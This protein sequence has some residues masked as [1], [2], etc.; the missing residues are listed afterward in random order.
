MSRL[1]KQASYFK[2]KEGMSVAEF[3]EYWRVRHAAVVQELPHLTRYVQNHVLPASYAQ[4]EPA[5]DGIAE[6][7]FESI[8]VMR[9]NAEHPALA[10]IRADEANFIDPASM[11]SIIAEER[12]VRAPEAGRPW[13]KLMALVKRL[14]TLP[15]TE[16]RQ[17]YGETLAPMVI[18]MPEVAGY[19]Q[20]YC[21]EGA[22]RDGR[23]PAFDA[24]ASLF[25]EDPAA[26]TAVVGSD[27]MAAVRDYERGIFRLDSIRAAVVREVPIV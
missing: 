10:R 9:D 18:A 12:V 17:R 1:I 21:R 5:F 20:S 22:Y 24:L 16:F 26:L 25:L 3:Q 14:E 15:L 6:V 13:V 7:W 8:D 27:E 11:G 4:V 19:I 2:R 23:E